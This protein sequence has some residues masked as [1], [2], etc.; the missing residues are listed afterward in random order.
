[1]PLDNPEFVTAAQASYLLDDELV[2]GLFAEGEARAYPVRMVFY[3]HV[4]NDTVG[5]RPILVTY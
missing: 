3:H 5:G 1:V 2:L 4:V